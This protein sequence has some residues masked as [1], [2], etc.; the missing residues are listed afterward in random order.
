[1]VGWSTKARGGFIELVVI[2]G[3]A[4]LVTIRWLTSR[5]VSQV[6]TL[7][8]GALLGFGWWVNNQILY[9]LVP[10]A[11]VMLADLLR[12]SRS[13]RG[14]LINTAIAGSCGFLLGGAPY[15]LYNLENNFAS[16]GMFETADPQGILEHLKGL[17]S[18]ALPILL[19]AR[20]FWE[21]QEVFPSA[22]LTISVVYIALLAIYLVHRP[23]E[24]F[25]LLALRI[26]RRKPLEML[27]IFF[28]STCA[29]FCVSS[30][31]YLIQAPRYL[32]PLY[33]SI[34]ILSGYALSRLKEWIGKAV[35]LLVC[36]IL[37][38]NLASVHYRASMH[39][40]QPEVFEGQRV[41]LDHHELL[42][43]LRKN[44]YLVVQTN[45]W[46]GYR[47]AFESQEEIRFVIFGEPRQVRIPQYQ[48]ISSATFADVLT[49][50]YV[51][52]PKQAKIVG[53]ALRALGYS[54][55]V[56][57]LSGYD[58]FYQI[59]PRYKELRL[60]SEPELSAS[61][62]INPQE[63]SRA[64]D[65]DKHTRWGSAHPQQAG[66]EFVVELSPP[67]N[68]RGIRYELGEWSHDFPR[69]LKVEIQSPDGSN[70]QVVSPESYKAIRYLLED[71]SSLT[72]PF[73]R[74]DAE[75]LVFTQTGNDAVFDWSVAEIE[76]LD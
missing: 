24:V 29:I 52:V 75:R 54:F 4:F 26:D 31:G 18:T 20:R 53:Q 50:P 51:L 16:F 46:I 34:F 8:I 74:L 10:I 66:M 64:V 49:V 17:I 57:R 3:I 69:G 21:S 43:W 11:F 60:V 33:I 42:D 55:Q 39:P 58:V 67:H 37:G 27:L 2:G 5:D 68:L 35:Y 32:L 15:W 13:E 1:L 40:S 7:L 44:Q 23:R 62:S 25:G 22:T 56:I 45:Y 61:S 19:G 71:R 48:E 38:I 28:L 41:S 47:L 73:D 30:F 76:L 14:A 70:H 63:A 59:A 6:R 72:L 36:L 12:G 9:F 65:G